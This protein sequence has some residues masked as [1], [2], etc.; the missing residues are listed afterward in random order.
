MTLPKPALVAFSMALAAQTSMAVESPSTLV[1]PGVFKTK[2]VESEHKG[3]NV[4]SNNPLRLTGADISYFCDNEECTLNPDETRHL[5]DDRLSTTQIFRLADHRE[6]WKPILVCE[7]GVHAMLSREI[8]AHLT[9]C[10]V[11]HHAR[12]DETKEFE[13][14]AVCR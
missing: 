2:V 7:Y 5:N 4:Y 10:T 9:L 13:F 14:E 12:F 11:T 3:W 1:C 8:P 6:A